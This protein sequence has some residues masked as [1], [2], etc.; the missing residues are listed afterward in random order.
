VRCVSAGC[1]VTGVEAS[2]AKRVP[3]LYPNKV[4]EIVLDLKS[5][6]VEYK[7]SSMEGEEVKK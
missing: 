4:R 7:V 2:R 1:N 5:D 3:L 6:V